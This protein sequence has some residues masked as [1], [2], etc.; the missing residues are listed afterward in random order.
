MTS[1][2]RSGA[3]SP[4]P[5][6]QGLLPL[7]PARVSIDVIAGATLAALAV[8]EVM[9]YTKIAGMP[10]ITGLY[11]LLLPV[12]LFA[13][14]GSSRHL[15]VGADS[16]T[17]AILALPAVA[18]KFGVRGGGYTLSNSGAFRLDSLAAAGAQAPATREI[19][20]NLLGETLLGDPRPP[21]KVLFVYNANPVSTLPCQEKV[22]SGMQREDLFTI[23]F[24]QVMTDT[25][26]YADI[27][28][29]ATTFLERR[30]LSR[31]AFGRRPPA[32]SI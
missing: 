13:I 20:M 22:R 32:P 15:V 26:A 18:G 24:E 23:V 11:T 25:A 30:E 14:F 2:V 1:P 12:L 27:L 10:V 28:L 9:G 16:A 7:D 4:L 8:P 3:R 21:V 29:P 17:A 19:N 5:I 6:L 31:A